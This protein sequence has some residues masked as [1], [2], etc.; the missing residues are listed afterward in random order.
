MTI[1][2]VYPYNEAMIAAP[3]SIG[4]HVAAGLR[5]HGYEVKQHDWMDKSTI[6]PSPGDVLLGHYHPETGY[7][8]RNSLTSPWR[9]KIA[10]APFNGVDLGWLMPLVDRYLAICGPYWAERLPPEWPAVHVDMAVDPN[11]YRRQLNFAEIGRRTIGYFGCCVPDK[12]TEYLAQLSELINS[13]VYHFGPG[14]VGGR[15]VECGHHDFRRGVPIMDFAANCG[16]HDANPTS[17]LEA[18]CWGMIN[19]CTPQSGWGADVA[20]HIP[21]DA[22]AEAAAVI[23]RWLAAP[24]EQLQARRAEVDS[25]LP[26]YSWEVFLSRVLEAVK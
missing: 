5:A 10:M 22:P 14:S 24:D 20:I 1:H 21:L 13:K 8:F 15:V 3:W 6:E 23:N 16:R 26:R 9:K 4:N 19:F 12:G 25:T 2:F 11:H 18:A 17:M 7:I